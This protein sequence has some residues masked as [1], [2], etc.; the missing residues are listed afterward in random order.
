MALEISKS[1]T[2]SVSVKELLDYFWHHLEKDVDIL[3]FIL[4]RNEVDAS[5]LVH[6]ILHE[7]LNV[8]IDLSQ[9]TQYKH[10]ID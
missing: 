10:C 6:S 7:M 1:I 2:P 4:Q 8:E 9:G 3:S 5:L